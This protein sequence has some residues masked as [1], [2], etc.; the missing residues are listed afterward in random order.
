E[1]IDNVDY[2]IAVI[3]K[4][5]IQS[6]WVKRELDVAMN[7]EIEQK[8]VFV[9]P[10]LID[11]VD[12]PG[13]LKGKLF[14]DF[15][16]NE[17]Y[18]KELEKV[19]QKLGPAQEPPSYTKEEFEKLKTEYEEAK[20][21]VDFYLHTTEQHMKIKSEQRS[22]EV[23]SKIDKAN[24]EYPEFV[25]INNAYAFEVGGIVVTLNYLLWALDKSIKRGGHPLEALLTIENKW[26]ET[27]IMLKA[28]SDYL[29]LD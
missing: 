19:L 4:S 29:R 10:I 18:D 11:D 22:P 28:Y 3:S 8:E 5:S 21:F 16:N 9:L 12:L 27:Q 6:E 13:F 20:A 26:L 15:R 23:Q 1:G 14:A 7:I 2:V 24:I 17:F 25:H